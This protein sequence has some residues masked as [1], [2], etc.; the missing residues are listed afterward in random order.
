MKRYLLVLSMFLIVL[1]AHVRAQDDKKKAPPKK[2]VVPFELIKTQH[3]VVNVKINGKGPYRLVFDTGAPDSL[4]SNKVFKEAGLTAKGGGLPIFGSRGQTKIKEIEV[5]D[6]K[7]E[8]IS[9]MVLDHPTVQAIANFVGPIEGILGFTFYARYKMSIDYEKKLITFE[10]GE[11][12]P[13]NVMDALMKKMLAPESVRR[14]PQILAPA[15]LLGIR[16]E[17]AKEDEEAGVTVKEVLPDSPA[18]AAGFKAGD[19]LLTLDG[20]WTDTVNDCYVAAGHIRLSTPV[21]AQVLRD[22]KKVALKITVR[23]GL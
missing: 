1:P 12:V 4:I 16:V 3:M 22:G 15:G 21:M 17:K 19:R 18:F 11:Y 8:D 6:L 10:P 13:G 14:S 7:A 9:A 5:G 23:A 20:R 2:F